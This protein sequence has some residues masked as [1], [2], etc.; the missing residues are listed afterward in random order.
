M[1]DLTAVR[2]VFFLSDHTGITAESLGRS[3]LTQFDSLRFKY[4]T[5]PFL[6]DAA[7]ANLAKQRINQ[8]AA[9]DGV[10]PLI[11]ST[12]VNDELRAIVEGSH[13]LF[14]DF[15]T[16]F[17]PMLEQELATT[18]AHVTGRSHG[19]NDYAS[20][21]ARIDALNFALANDDGSTTQN[22]PIADIVLVGVSRAGKTPTS[23]YMALQYGVL[24]ANYPLAEEDFEQPRLP[25]LLQAHRRKVYG[26]T[27]DPARLHHIRTERLPN[28]RYASLAQCQMEIQAVEM[29]LR[30]EQIPFTNTTAMSIEEIATT[31]MQRA[32]VARRAVA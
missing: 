30:R 4:V 10:R 18:S 26:L 5:W 8:A 6:D 16:T 9:E 17:N 29:M 23:L 24:A 25:R 7:K 32:G 3:L 19:I 12:L 1:G 13:G 22:Y 27:I 28:S 21:S 31:I 20:Y 2:S 14:I 15:F 11:F